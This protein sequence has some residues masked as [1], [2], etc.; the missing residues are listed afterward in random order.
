[1]AL[2]LIVINLLAS[3]ALATATIAGMASAYGWM[4]VHLRTHVLLAMFAAIS[5]LFGHS[6]TMFYFIGTGVRLKELVAEHTVQEEDL[7]RPTIL[8]KMRVFPIT[9]LAILATIV[10]FILGGGVD[11]G[12]LPG[13]VHLILALT[14]LALQLAAVQKET[15]AIHANV[16]LFDRLEE[17]LAA[18]A[19]G[20]A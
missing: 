3:V 18:R 2:A 13:W 14:A 10:T 17:I 6:M 5:V 1:M 9:M 16:R 15:W 20:R 8:F 19:G 7:I 12:S 4:E 11:T